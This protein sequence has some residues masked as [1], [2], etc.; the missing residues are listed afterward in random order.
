MTTRK[1][2]TATTAAATAVVDAAQH[3][4]DY[5]LLLSI[6]R[7]NFSSWWQGRPLFLAN[8]PEGREK[9]LFTIYLENLDES[10][11]QEHNCHAC[12][13]FINLYGRLVAVDKDGRLR[14]V[15]WR[16]MDGSLETPAAYV[17]AFAAMRDYLET[18]GEI[19]S[20][21]V[22]KESVWGKPI[23]GL[24]R[25][26]SVL[27]P[28]V[29]T[30]RVVT[31]SQKMAQSIQHY[32]SVAGA[33]QE[34]RQATLGQAVHL[35]RTE[36]LA[37]SQK[38]LGPTEWLLQTLQKCGDLNSRKKRALLWQ[39]VATA[40]EGYLHPKASV[41]WPVLEAINNGDSLAVLQRKFGAMTH[42]LAYQRPQKAP[43]AQTVQ[44]AQK[45][46][47]QL[48]IAASLPRRFARLDEVAPIWITRKRS[49][50]HEP[51]TGMFV[52]M[53]TRETDQVLVQPS[54]QLGPA[55]IFTWVKFRQTI[56]PE[57]VRMQLYTPIGRGRYIAMTT[58]VNAEAPEIFKWEGPLAWYV[59]NDGSTASQWNLQSGMWTEVTGVATLPCPA[60]ID[61]GAVLALDGCRDVRNSSSALFPSC[62]ADN[63]HGV[64]SV[65]EEYSNTTP[66]QQFLSMTQPLACGY[67]VRKSQ[68][69]CTLRVLSFGKWQ[70]IKIDRWD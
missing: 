22:S 7:D 30:D 62:L 10:I 20:V 60:F 27:N 13:S 6:V 2:N 42:G 47:E 70:S 23:D 35:F 11:R 4:H 67:D 66:L 29:H 41:L 58:A 28:H 53:R 63:L 24:W 49:R 8:L 57:A 31:P 51:T 16:P 12:R 48:G 32:E 9:F 18:Q 54:N 56:L 37:Q 46:V 33:L 36:Q 38:F 43:H 3:T 5:S 59:Y 34:V 64:R 65:I 44:Q 45:L 17:E 26:I 19:G 69:D 15:M 1:R 39:A 68:A 61:E 52:G 55:R 40:P 50:Q 14:S 25:H 21:F